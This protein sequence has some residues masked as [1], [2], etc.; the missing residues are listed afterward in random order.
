MIET[1][2]T[3]LPT[4]TIHEE[5]LRFT[6]NTD[7]EGPSP[8]TNNTGERTT[9]SCRGVLHHNTI[10]F[11]DR[12]DLIYAYHIQKNTNNNKTLRISCRAFNHEMKNT[13]L[14]IK[15]ENQITDMTINKNNI[16]NIGHSWINFY[17][18]E[19]N[20]KRYHLMLKDED[21]YFINYSYDTI[22]IKNNIS[23]IYDNEENT[24][25]FNAAHNMIEGKDLNVVP[26]LSQEINENNKEIIFL[27][28]KW[29]KSNI[30]FQISLD[31]ETHNLVLELTYDKQFIK[32]IYDDT[33]KDSD[34]TQDFLRAKLQ[35]KI[36]NHSIIFIKL[37]ENKCISIDDITEKTFTE[38]TTPEK[39]EK[40]IKDHM[41]YD[42]N[43]DEP[44]YDSQETIWSKY[45][46]QIYALILLCIC[47]I[48]IIILKKYKMN[49]TE[50]TEEL[51]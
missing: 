37:Y 22:K 33:H 7:R 15:E 47:I 11:N 23:N 49:D 32:I 35:I 30:N 45:K 31:I 2:Q 3:L 26:F 14:Q 43:E 17:Y 28:T 13:K 46:N 1:E 5:K 25:V 4:Y 18:I 24:R 21:I 19:N 27:K 16:H 50:S 36:N 41:I 48:I 42:K 29:K 38:L 12:N 20:K 51:N 8:S 10:I 39:C 6:K 9:A 34:N 40:Y 44:S